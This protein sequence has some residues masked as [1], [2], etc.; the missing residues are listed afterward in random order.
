MFD[1][2]QPPPAS[3][4]PEALG[5]RLRRERERR[6]VDLQA[7]AHAT[8]V[9]ASV[10]AEMENGN[11]SK[12]PPGIFGRSFMRAYAEAVGLDADAILAEFLAVAP[13]GEPPPPRRKAARGPDLPPVTFTLTPPAL[14]P[15]EMALQDQEAALERALR[16]TLDEPDAAAPVRWQSWAGRERLL[17]LVVDVLFLGIVGAAAW[18]LSGP[19]LVGPAVA[20]AAVVYYGASTVVFGCSATLWF[21]THRRA[22]SSSGGAF[23]LRSERVGGHAPEALTALRFPVHRFWRRGGQA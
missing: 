1:K 9:N 13:D 8:K 2:S 23:V 19:P 18:F 11:F 10:F 4:K 15:A 20:A 22:T 5:A 3:P 17:S 21:F 16:L 7:V 6:G 14:S 12:W